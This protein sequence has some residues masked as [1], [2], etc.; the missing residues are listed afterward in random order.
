M[1]QAISGP[2][3]EASAEADTDRLFD[4]PVKPITSL[5]NDLL[6]R[7]YKLITRAP[8]RMFAVS[9]GYGCTG[10][11][12]TIHEVITEAR[13]LARFCEASNRKKALGR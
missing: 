12:A 11:K 5:P 3:T 9:T 1:Y 8:N 13:D 4:E 7:G 2:I 10:T 6:T